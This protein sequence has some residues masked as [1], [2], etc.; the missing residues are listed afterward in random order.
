MRYYFIF[1]NVRLSVL[2]SFAVM[3]VIIVFL[4]LNE[5]LAILS[6]NLIYLIFHQAFDHRKGKLNN[7]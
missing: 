3:D 5:I 1:L 6:T 4:I 2:L 7:S